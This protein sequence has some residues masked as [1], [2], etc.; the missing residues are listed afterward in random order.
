MSDYGN[1]LS[2]KHSRCEIMSETKNFG[3]PIVPIEI[4]VIYIQEIPACDGLYR[5]M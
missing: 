5:G 1:L 2:E 4:L 3:Y